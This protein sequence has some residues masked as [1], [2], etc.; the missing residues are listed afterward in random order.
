M[1]QL[2]ELSAHKEISIAEAAE[3]KSVQPITIRRWIQQGKLPA[4]RYGPKTIRIKLSDLDAMG[5]EVN[6]IT[7]RHVQG[8]E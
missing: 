6:P 7:R 5:V 1:S 3:L 8:G 2:A 4:Y